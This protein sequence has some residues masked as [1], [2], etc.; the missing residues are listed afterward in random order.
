MEGTPTRS[1]RTATSESVERLPVLSRKEARTARVPPE[2]QD[3]VQTTES[4][5][6]W[7]VSPSTT[8]VNTLSSRRFHTSRIA[9][10]VFWMVSELRARTKGANVSPTKTGTGRDW[11]ANLRIPTNVSVAVPDHHT[12]CV[13]SL[14]V[15]N[16]E[17]S[18]RRLDSR[19]ICRIV[20]ACRSQPRVWSE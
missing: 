1:R 18:T 19:K 2:V 13:P 14:C 7:T 11:A 8:A 15:F 20:S 9:E 6:G 3:R 4:P 12:A 16:P 5:T 10:S 17:I